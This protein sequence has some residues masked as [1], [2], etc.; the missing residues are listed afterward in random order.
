MIHRHTKGMNGAKWPL[1]IL[2][3]CAV[4]GVLVLKNN[5]S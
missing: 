1:I 3:L 4:P 2:G 5:L